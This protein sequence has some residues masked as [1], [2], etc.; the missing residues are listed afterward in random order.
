MFGVSLFLAMHGS[1]VTSF[2]VR[3]STENDSQNR[4]YKLGQQEETYSILTT[5]GYF[6]CL[7]FQDPRL[8][9]TTIAAPVAT[10]QPT[11]RP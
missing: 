9:T 7:T 11:K 10:A 3:K 5:H 2:L 8:T 1:L 4:D 6:G